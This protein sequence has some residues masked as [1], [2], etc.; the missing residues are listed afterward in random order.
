M[1]DFRIVEIVF[2]NTKVFYRYETVGRSGIGGEDSP[3]Y[4]SAKILGHFRGTGRDRIRNGNQP[5]DV[6]SAALNAN[7][8]VGRVMVTLSGTRKQ[9]NADR[10][11]IVQKAI[12]AGQYHVL[13][14]PNR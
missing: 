9:A 12:A 13:N 1:P 10:I 5:T 6:E 14:H 3:P 4:P 2:D 7:F 8:A 11:N